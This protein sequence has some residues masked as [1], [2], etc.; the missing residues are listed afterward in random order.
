MPVLIGTEHNGTL[1]WLSVLL[2]SF[3]SFPTDGFQIEGWTFVL[4]LLLR[5]H[6]KY[7]LL[8][9]C[10]LFISLLFYLPFFYMQFP[11]SQNISKKSNLEFVTRVEIF[12]KS[13]CVYMCIP[14]FHIIK[15][16]TLHSFLRKE[17]VFV[18]PQSSIVPWWQAML[19]IY[20]STNQ[21]ATQ[22]SI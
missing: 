4:C 6:C 12:T 2:I 22:I 11:L 3:V 16:V 7:L 19:N 8:L 21:E 15:K 1:T 5:V 14:E 20:Y 10:Y 9:L 18:V 13:K 17:T